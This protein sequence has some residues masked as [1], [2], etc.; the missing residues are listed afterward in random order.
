MRHL[1]TSIVSFISWHRRAVGAILAAGSVLLLASALTA[2]PATRTVVSLAANLPAGHRL[3][4][5]DLTLRSLPP[6]ALPDETL[7]EIGDAVG[8]T[9]AVSL[10]SDTVLQPGLLTGEVTLPPGRVVVPITVPEAALRSLLRPGD[11]LSLVAPG[12]EDLVVLSADARVVAHP[13]NEAPDSQLGLATGRDSGLLLVEVDARE[14][15]LVASLGQSGQVSVVL[16][17]L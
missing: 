2:P 7:T 17:S 3:S 9:T 8:R 4:A 15:A 14:A 10:N 12:P 11:V 6:E 16:G 5:T 1:L 13:G